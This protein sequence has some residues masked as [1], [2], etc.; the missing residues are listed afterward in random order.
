[1]SLLQNTTKKAT[2][3]NAREMIIFSLPKIGK[4]ELMTKLPGSYLILDFEGG[5]DFYDCEGINVPDLATFDQLGDEFI[6]TNPHFN[7]IVIDTLTSMYDKL[8]N[9]IAVRNYNR[10]EKRNKD[11]DWDITIVDYGKGQVYKRDA[12]KK[13]I[14]FFKGYCNCLILSAHVAEKAMASGNGENIQVNDLDVEGKMKNIL[15]LKTDAMGLLYRSDFNENTLSF[16]TFIGDT[17][18]FG[19]KQSASTMGKIGGTRIPHLSGQKFVISKKTIPDPSK[20][21]EYELETF[22]DK[23]FIK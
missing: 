3:K 10:E 19:K 5:T 13:V 15:A 22:W 23:I 2:A 7:F 11:L 20:P 9:Q 18:K 4:T 1:M 17:T 16:E 12:L 21:E 6:E 8:I 14:D